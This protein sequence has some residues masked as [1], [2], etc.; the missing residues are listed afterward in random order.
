MSPPKNPDVR[1]ARRCG[2]DLNDQYVNLF[3]V[4]PMTEES[5]KVTGEES[6]I[7]LSNDQQDIFFHTVNL[8][9]ERFSTSSDIANKCLMLA[10]KPLLINGVDVRSQFLCYIPPQE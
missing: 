5:R 10:V 4:G 3:T 9:L 8:L 1:A 7:Q 6:I 2:D